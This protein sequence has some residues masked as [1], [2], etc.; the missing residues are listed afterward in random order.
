MVPGFLHC[1]ELGELG[2]CCPATSGSGSHILFTLSSKQRKL[3]AQ[4]SAEVTG[5][6]GVD[7]KCGA[8]SLSQGGGFT[9]AAGWGWGGSWAH[10]PAARSGSCCPA[11]AQ[12]SQSLPRLQRQRGQVVGFQCRPQDALWSE[13]PREGVLA[14]RPAEGTST[15]S[16][17][18]LVPLR[19]PSPRFPVPADGRVRAADRLPGR[20]QNRRVL[21][22]ALWPFGQV[23]QLSEPGSGICK[24]GVLASL[25]PGLRGVGLR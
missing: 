18:P 22:K 9:A 4:G 19:T 14:D 23:A 3:E 5:V 21:P 20:L 11:R 25:C 8:H 15:W 24:P 13:P 2:G 1:L 17:L 10:M 7:R 12:F 16:A 6:G